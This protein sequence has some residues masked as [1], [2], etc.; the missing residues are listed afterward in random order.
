M[1]ACVYIHVCVYI[2]MC[3]FVC[4]HVVN[5][6]IW[7]WLPA[8]N[9]DFC[10]HARC[11]RSDFLPFRSRNV[12]SSFNGSHGASAFQ[13]LCVVMPCAWLCECSME[14]MRISHPCV[15]RN[16]KEV[17]SLS[18]YWEIIYFMESQE[19]IIKP[20]SLFIYRQGNRHAARTQ[21]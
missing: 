14:I 12:H 2:C 1:Y 8:F 3:V 21:G 9:I 15:C 17:T 20:S 7:D 16:I 11:T 13:L 19:V 18:P 5:I 6:W 4:L 10:F